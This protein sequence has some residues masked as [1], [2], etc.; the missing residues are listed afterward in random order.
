MTDPTALFTRLRS[1]PGQDN[2]YLSGLEEHTFWIQVVE[3]QYHNVIVTTFDSRHLQMLVCYET[4][5]V[6]TF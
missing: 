1:A 3:P 5:R 4:H 6:I 2:K